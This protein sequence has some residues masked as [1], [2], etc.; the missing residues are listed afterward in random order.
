MRKRI[1][2]ILRGH[3]RTWEYNSSAVFKCLT[4]IDADVD[5]FISIWQT[6]QVKISKLY[7]TFN[8][9]N[10]EHCIKTM[11]FPKPQDYAYSGWQGPAFLSNCIAPFVR[12]HHIENPYDMVI[13]TRPDVIWNVK[14][15]KSIIWPEKNTLYSTART[16]HESFRDKKRHLG[17]HDHLL[18]STPD[19]FCTMSERVAVTDNKTLESHCDMYNFARSRDINVCDNIDWL[20]VEIT[21]PSDVDYTE[22]LKFF[23]P[24]QGAR[25]LWDDIS[26]EERIKYLNEQ[27]I[28]KYDYITDNTNIAIGRDHLD[29]VDNANVD[30]QHYSVYTD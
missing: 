23:D 6:P 25:G 22:P 1:A 13:D 14:Q 28:E 26:I 12:L 15:G 19:V 10:R 18:I 29:L 20:N 2:V 21:R 17:I 30:S 3:I 4:K 7:R 16:N 24:D 27:D 5:Y 8:D 11:I 9:N